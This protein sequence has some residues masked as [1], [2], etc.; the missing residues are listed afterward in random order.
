MSRPVHARLVVFE[1]AC[2]E[3]LSTPSSVKSLKSPENRREPGSRQNATLFM[4]RCL[5][6]ANIIKCLMRINF[7]LKFKQNIYLSVS[8]HFSLL[9]EQQPVYVVMN[10]PSWSVWVTFLFFFVLTVGGDKLWSTCKWMIRLARYK[11]NK[12]ATKDDNELDISITCHPHLSS[13]NL[14]S[15]IKL[16]VD[17]NTLTTTTTKFIPKIWNLLR[18]LFLKIHL[19]M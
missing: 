1:T 15:I 13:L 17:R 11:I 3:R 9:S 10:I 18:K 4:L 14:T 19:T 2:C 5:S 12:S 6:I 8:I 16:S 7:L